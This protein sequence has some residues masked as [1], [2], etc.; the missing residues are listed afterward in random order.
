MKSVLKEDYYRSSPLPVGGGHSGLVDPLSKPKLS[1]SDIL[2]NANDNISKNQPLLQSYPLQTLADDVGAAVQ[3]T[4]GV[5]DKLKTARDTN[6]VFAAKKEQLTQVIA[7]LEQ[8][9]VKYKNVVS[10][11]NS[12]DKTDV[13]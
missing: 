2:R 10:V 4:D 3:K 9:S 5:I 11:L 12:L 6:V 13:Q 7:E 1:F 8:I